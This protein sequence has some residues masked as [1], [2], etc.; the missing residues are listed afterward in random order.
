MYLKASVRE[1]IT[2]S[3]TGFTLPCHL[4]V[5]KSL[6]RAWLKTVDLHSFDFMLF[7]LSD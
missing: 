7:L 5:L 3:G 2:T 4:S 1:L 6:K